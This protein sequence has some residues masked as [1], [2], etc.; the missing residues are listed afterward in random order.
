VKKLLLFFFLILFFII[1]FINLGRFVDITQKPVTADI[2]VSLGG[3]DSSGS[4]LKRTLKLY[5]DGFSRSG[6]IIFTG[7]IKKYYYSIWGIFLENNGILKENIIYIDQSIAYNTMEEVLFIKKYMLKHYMK[8]V[9]FVSHPQH[10]RRITILANNVARYKEAGLNLIVVS[11]EP[12]QWNRDEYYK[13]IISI[14]NTISEIVKLF[15]NFIKYSAPFIQ[16]TQFSKKM[17]NNEWEKALEQLDEH[18]YLK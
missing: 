10:S 15:Y 16:Y 18:T 1:I 3:G 4:R 11:V 12:R 14:R 2:I 8:S 9:I 17:Q 6:K 5:K 13:N 7:G